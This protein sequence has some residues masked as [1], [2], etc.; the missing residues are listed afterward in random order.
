MGLNAKQ[1]KA[2]AAAAS[3]LNIAIAYAL[4][5]LVSISCPV[6][7]T[8]TERLAL[9]SFCLGRYSRF[10][11]RYLLTVINQFEQRFVSSIYCI[12]SSYLLLYL[13]HE[14]CDGALRVDRPQFTRIAP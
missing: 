4:S 2:V 10:F 6:A 9:K 12:H 14:H 5:A 11:R 13:G 3:G 8:F 1:P 7:D